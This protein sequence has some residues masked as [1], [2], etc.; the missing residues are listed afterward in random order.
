MAAKQTGL[1]QKKTR[2]PE[3]CRRCALTEPTCCS[4][5]PGEEELLP[6][7][8]LFELARML[9]SRIRA[10]EEDYVVLVANSP[11]FL[12][13]MGRLFPGQRQTLGRIFPQD[14]QHLRLRLDQTNRCAL[15]GPAGCLLPVRARPLICRLYPFWFAGEKILVFNNPHCQA[16]RENRNI[17]ALHQAFGTSEDKLRRLYLQL[18]QELGLKP[19]K[20]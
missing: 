5:R 3:V 6:P 15:L 17:T 19:A 10:S 4:C 9:A 14:G 1:G 20:G 16:L 18:C 8:S 11:A 2:G 7:I 13:Q 12:K